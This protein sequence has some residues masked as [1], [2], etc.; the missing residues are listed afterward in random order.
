MSHHYSGTDFSFPQGVGRLD[1]TD[2][3]AFPKPRETGKSILSVN[4]HPT[5]GENP[6]GP[7]TTE[8]F[9][10]EAGY[11][12]KLD[13]DGDAGANTAQRWRFSVVVR[14]AQAASAH[15]RGT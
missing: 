1:F 12:A 6:P 3:Y 9:A 7:T 4:V 10:P 11:E 14:G 13:T 8:A 5:A 2:L 15:P